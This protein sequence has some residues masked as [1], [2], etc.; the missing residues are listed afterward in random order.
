MKV[1]IVGLE[2]DLIKSFT[3]DDISSVEHISIEFHGQLNI[4]L[5]ERTLNAINKLKSIEV[6]TISNSPTHSWP[7]EMLFL[8]Q[9]HIQF[10]FLQKFY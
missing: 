8:N 10:N 5:H 9:N 4:S 6:I 1:D 3:I 7:V 2:L